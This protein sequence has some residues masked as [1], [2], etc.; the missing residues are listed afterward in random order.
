M[1]LFAL[2]V[3]ITWNVYTYSE[4]WLHRDNLAARAENLHTN[5]LRWANIRGAW[6]LYFVAK[7]IFHIANLIL[8]I[9][10]IFG[11]K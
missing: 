11:W 9:G 5:A 6:W 4:W 8:L 7:V 10:V 1:K 3:L 2:L